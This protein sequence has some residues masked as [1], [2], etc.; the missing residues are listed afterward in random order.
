MEG[1][2][3]QG[4][5]PPGSLKCWELSNC[6]PSGFSIRAELHEVYLVIDMR[7]I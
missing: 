7:F 4:N 2:C 1:S 5:E 3:E 6:A